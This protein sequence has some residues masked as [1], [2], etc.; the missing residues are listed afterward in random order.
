MNLN[1]SR[2]YDLVPSSD[3]PQAW[4]LPIVELMAASEEFVPVTVSHVDNAGHFWVQRVS[5]ADKTNYNQIR[6]IIGVDG[7][8]TFFF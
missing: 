1:L 8:C 5:K 7:I 3:L 2:V 6:T 4:R